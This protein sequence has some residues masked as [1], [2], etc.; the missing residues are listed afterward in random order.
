[1]EFFTV[2]VAIP[3]P[4][5]STAF[6]ARLGVGV[7]QFLAFKLN[8]DFNSIGTCGSE[9]QKRRNQLSRRKFWERAYPASGVSADMFRHVPE[10]GRPPV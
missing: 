9:Q 2:D 7:V 10:R 4:S 5:N 8:S 6:T 3:Q 1:M